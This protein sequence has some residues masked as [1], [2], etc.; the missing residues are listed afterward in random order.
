MSAQ[1]RMIL[2][3]QWRMLMNFYRRHGTASFI[4]ATLISILWYTGFV[5]IALAAAVYLADPKLVQTVRSGIGT[6]FFFAFFYWQ[7]MPL[8]LASTGRLLDTKKL[9]AYPVADGDLFKIELLLRTVLFAEMPIVMLGVAVGLL[10]NPTL[11]KWCALAPLLFTIFNIALGAGIKDLVLRLLSRK[12]IREVFLL[13][14][15]LFAAL[16]SFLAQRGLPGGLKQWMSTLNIDVLPWIAAGHAS[17]AERGWLPWAILIPLTLLAWLFSRWQ[18]ERS[19]QFD[20]D[21]ARATEA[22]DRGS[23]LDRLF[24]WPNRVFPDPLGALVEKELRFLSRVSRF[25]IV[26]FMGFSF[27]LLIWLP[28][29]MRGQGGWMATNFLTVVAAYSLLLL[30]EV[31]FYN[32]FGFDRAA[33]QFYFVV[34][35]RSTTVLIAKNIAASFF[36]IAEITVV[37][38]ACAVLRMPVTLPKIAE[39]ACVSIVVTLF[40]LTIGN[41]GST[42]S[43]RAQNPNDGWRRSSSKMALLALAAYPLI[44]LPVFLSYLARWAFREESAFF[45][46]IACAIFIAACFY[47][48]SISTAADTMEKQRDEFL[49]LLTQ[50]DSPVV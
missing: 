32:C 41:I 46:T 38:I 49:T 1:A 47:W 27:G 21:A 3:T 15:V 7:S 5:V 36:V 43:P 44:L 34:P 31:C 16:P 50:S 17:T 14:V 6:G 23:K 28:M 4:F 19:L 10:R 20:S 48:V 40:L 26:F 35:V 18:F 8:M 2:A 33:V 45:A 12:G 37:T 30:S 25:R 39:A 13:V 11:P 9:R 22:T 29:A 42:R 24:G